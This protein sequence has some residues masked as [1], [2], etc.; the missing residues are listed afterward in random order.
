MHPKSHVSLLLGCL[1]PKIVYL[2]A[3]SFTGHR[4]TCKLAFNPWHQYHLWLSKGTWTMPLKCWCM[5]SNVRT[6]QRIYISAVNSVHY[7]NKSHLFAYFISS[8][9]FLAFR[10]SSL[11]SNSSLTREYFLGSFRIKKI[12]SSTDILPGLPTVIAFFVYKKIELNVCINDLYLY[13]KSKWY[14]CDLILIP[15]LM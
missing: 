13:Y 2:L 10:S 5:T 14:P 9:A 7:C 11:M 15:F 12:M 1:V 4:Q 3:I 6:L 8:N